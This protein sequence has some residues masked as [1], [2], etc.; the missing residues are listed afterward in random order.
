[1]E[2]VKGGMVAEFRKQWGIQES[3]IDENGLKQ[4]KEKD[5]SKHTHHTI[6]AI[7]IACMTKDKYDVLAEIWGLENEQKKKKE[8]QNPLFLRGIFWFCREFFVCGEALSS[9]LFFLGVWGCVLLCS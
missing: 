2:S 8:F 3:Y 5:R 6:D 1:M 4:Y 7:T 9:S